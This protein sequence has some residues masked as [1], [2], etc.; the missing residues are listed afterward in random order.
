M[1]NID[2]RNHQ[3]VREPDK[4]IFD[5]MNKGVLKSNG[6]WMLFMNAGDRINADYKFKPS[7]NFDVLIGKTMY[8]SI[9]RSPLDTR[10]LR[11]GKILGS[12]QSILYKRAVF[13]S[14]HFF[15]LEPVVY[16][17][18]DHLCRIYKAGYQF[19]FIDDIIAHRELGGISGI[20]SF[21]NTY[22]RYYYIIKNWGL[23]GFYYAVCNSIKNILFKYE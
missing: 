19:G 13:D 8:N 21:K 22:S 16:S 6:A 5:A 7:P 14:N 11:K 12:H 9:T 17:D 15:S 4:G 3:Y 23:A 10:F 18:Y 2:L 20:R 1:R